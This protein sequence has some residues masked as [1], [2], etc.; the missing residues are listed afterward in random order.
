MSDGRDSDH[1]Y[2][3][4]CVLGE[5]CRQGEQASELL[6]GERT[7]AV[8]M[9]ASSLMVSLNSGGS[10]APHFERL[11]TGKYFKLESWR[12]IS[13]MY[14]HLSEM[15]HKQPQLTIACVCIK[16][17]ALNSESSTL[18]SSRSSLPLNAGKSAHQAV[19]TVSASVAITFAFSTSSI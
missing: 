19:S 5:A 18:P 3:E 4:T 10:G 12:W 13:T 8:C 7:L 11:P 16:M 6:N 9:C 1:A 2:D 17:L 15:V 14:L